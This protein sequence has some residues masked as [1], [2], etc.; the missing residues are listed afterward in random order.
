MLNRGPH[1]GDLQALI[2][3]LENDQ[4]RAELLAKLRALNATSAT[5]PEPDYLGGAL[6]SLDAAV[7]EPDRPPGPDA[8]RR[9]QTRCSRCRSCSAGSKA[10]SPSPSAAPYGTRSAR[11]IGG[12]V[13][14]GFIASLVVRAILR[15][16]RDRRGLLPLEARRKARLRASAAHLAVNLAA[17]I[18]F[19][20]VTY[21]VLS[22]TAVSILGQRV[23]ADILFSIACVRAVTA[24]SKAYLAPENARRR[25][26]AM[27]DA[28]AIEAERWV[29][30]L[31]GLGLLRLFRPRRS[32]SAGAALERARVP[33]ATCC[34]SSWLC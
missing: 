28:A 8:G 26:S 18:T 24:L 1:T 22:Y 3:T 15:G 14:A 20:A 5:A 34:S 2:V 13:L 21:V 7:S 33:R 9:D 16:W 19:L 11:Q 12:A 27:D 29:A 31:F 10:S 23:A 32:A 4:A 6:D 30:T 17:L 25:L